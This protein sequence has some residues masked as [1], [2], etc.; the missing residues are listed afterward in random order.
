[1][2]K[3]K[4]LEGDEKAVK[5]EDKPKAQ[6]PEKVLLEE[7]KEPKKEDKPTERKPVLPKESSA[8]PPKKFIWRID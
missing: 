4:N 2:D 3:V 7:I 6:A 8:E 5:V 1:V